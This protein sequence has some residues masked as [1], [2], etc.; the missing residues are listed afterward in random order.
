MD[1]QFNQPN[2]N[3]DYNST[4][5]PNYNLNYDPYATQNVTPPTKRRFRFPSQFNRLESLVIVLCFSLMSWTFIWGYTDQG[6]VNRDIQREEHIFKVVEALD[7]FYKNSS[8]IASKRS[9][10]ISRCATSLNSVD[11]EFTLQQHLTGKVTKLDT[12]N[13]FTGYD[14]PTDPWGKYDT[15]QD[16]RTSDFPCPN[17]FTNNKGTLYENGQKSCDFSTTAKKKLKQCYSYK[18]DGN[19]ESYEIAYFSENQDTFQIYSKYRDQE[20]QDVTNPPV[21]TVP[22]DPETGLPVVEDE[23]TTN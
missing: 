7:S 14:F 20:L 23:N 15:T 10:P 17:L 2:Y 1:N 4:Y 8:K 3:T 22:I 6:R 13:Y 11:Y 21:V 16:K 19:G 5:N 18:S 9:Y 12:N